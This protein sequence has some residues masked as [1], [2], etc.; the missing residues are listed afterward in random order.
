MEPSSPVSLSRTD[1]NFAICFGVSAHSPEYRLSPPKPSEHWP[2]LRVA[3]P[4]AISQKTQVGV[5]EPVQ[6]PLLRSA[7]GTVVM[8]MP[9]ASA[10]AA[11]LALLALHLETRRR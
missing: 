5:V 4:S 8:L 7:Q 9:C 6:S 10:A 1:A 11:L 3:H 2:Q